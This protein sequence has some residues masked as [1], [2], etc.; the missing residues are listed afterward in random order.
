MADIK[1]FLYAWCG[2]KKLT[3]SYD[4]R[5]VGNK[6]RQKFMCEVRVDTYN[7]IGMG[8]ST[9]KKD[10]QTNAARDFVNYLVRI[11]EMNAAEV[12]APGVSKAPGDQPHDDGGP[13]AGGGAGV[14]FGSLPSSGP[15]PPHLVLK[16]EKEEAAC[17]GPIPGVTGLGYSGGRNSGWGGGGGGGGAEWE[18]GAN[19]KEYYVKRDEQEAQ[20]TLE[21]EEVDLNASLH[22]NWTLE[23]AKARLNQFFQKEKTSAEYKYSQVGPDHNRSFIAEMQLFVRQLGRRITAR[24]HGS[25]KKLAAQSCAL[26]LVR[27][28]FHL[29]VLEA[30]SGVTKK[31]EGETL[32]A[33]EVTVSPDLQQQLATVV[34]QLG[35]HV[36]P[37]PAD[38]SDSV[39]LIQGKLATFEPSQRQSGAGVVPWSPPQ[40]NWNPWTSSNIDDGPLAFVSPRSGAVEQWSSGAVEQ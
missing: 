18:R 40:V 13:A 12:P 15:L 29:G 19:L 16:T 8:N 31:K 9:N 26:S 7:Y 14:G 1:N 6:N 23:N 17:S 20:A 21:S 22:G 30:F 3:P 39:S 32:E 36:P 25:N 35:V 11:G 27:Q 24:E 10:A 5:A 4:I 34:Q 33:F 28:L 37:R 2:K 38:P